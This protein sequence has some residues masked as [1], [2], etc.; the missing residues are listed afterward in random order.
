M[1][2]SEL[3]EALSAIRILCPSPVLITL[4]THE[5]ALMIAEKYGYHIYDGL[6]ISAALEARCTTLYSEDLQD[7]HTIDGKLTIRNPFIR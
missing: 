4:D 3:F 5:A 1:S 2:W 7:G 6:V